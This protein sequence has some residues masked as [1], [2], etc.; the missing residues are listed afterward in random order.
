MGMCLPKECTSVILKESLEDLFKVL[1]VP[2]DILKIESDIQ[3]YAYSKDFL[4]YFT[5]C[6][7][8]ALLI[9]VVIAT[10]THKK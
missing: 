9:V 10:I 1:N 4:F 8:I 2:L 6:L 3:N 5:A 7:L